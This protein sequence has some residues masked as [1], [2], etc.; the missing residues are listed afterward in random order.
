MRILAPSLFLLTLSA[1][2]SAADDTAGGPGGGGP[3][4]RGG[5]CGPYAGTLGTTLTYAY[6]DAYQAETGTSGSMTSTFSDFD[7]ATGAATFTAI[8]TTVTAQTN[9]SSQGAQHLTCGADGVYL[10]SATYQYTVQ[11]NG[12]VYSGQVETTYDAP[13]LIYPAGLAEGSAWTSTYA[14]TNVDSNSGP[15]DFSYTQEAHAVRTEPVTVPA[16]TFDT[17]VVS[18]ASDGA[19]PYT[20]WLDV[21]LGAVQNGISVLASAE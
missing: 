7:A 1:C 6:T 14:G 19:Q 21:D 20:V 5:P 9:S 13:V 3:G 11:A 8:T 16:G 12:S 18:Y 2:T 15:N 4:L 17:L 10:D